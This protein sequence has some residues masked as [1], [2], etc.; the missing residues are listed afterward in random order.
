MNRLDPTSACPR[1]PVSPVNRGIHRTTTPGWGPLDGGSMD[2]GPR[3]RVAANAGNDRG[4]LT[5]S[6]HVVDCRYLLVSKPDALGRFPSMSMPGTA[7]ASVTVRAEP[8]SPFI[9]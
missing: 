5:R 1:T 3:G 4:V 2:S 9:K 6:R 7:L 8:A